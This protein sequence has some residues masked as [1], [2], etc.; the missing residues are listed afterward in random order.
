MNSVRTKNDHDYFIFSHPAE[1]FAL[2]LCTYIST[3]IP[4]PKCRM[5]VQSADANGMLLKY[6]ASYVTKWHD[7]FNDDA[8]FSVHVGPCEAAYRHLRGLRPLEPEMWLSLSSKKVHGPKAELRK[9]Q[10]QSLALSK[11]NL[12]RNI[13]NVQRKTKISHSKNGYETLMT[14]QRSRRDIRTAVP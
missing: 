12:T 6:A 13:A 4:S 2:N 11:Q 5:D 10:F 14:N 3:L 1:A 8:L 9:L 7:A